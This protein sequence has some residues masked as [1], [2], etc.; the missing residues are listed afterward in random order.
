L[1][2]PPGNQYAVKAKRWS[3]A[4]DRA[5]ERRSRAAGIE[6]LDELAEKLLTLADQ[7]DLQ[8]LKELGDRIEG[9]PTQATELSGPQGQPLT[10]IVNFVTPSDGSSG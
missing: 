6:A 2:A 10:T 8:A 7:G 9:K 5:L 1:S 3:Q 4:I